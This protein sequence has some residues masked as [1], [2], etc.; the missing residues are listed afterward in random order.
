MIVRMKCFLLLSPFLNQCNFEQILPLWLSGFDS[1]EVSCLV[2]L[3]QQP[4][5]LI[6]PTFPLVQF[7]SPK[8]ASKAT[9]ELCQLLAQVTFAVSPL[10]S[11]NEPIIRIPPPWCFRYNLQHKFRLGCGLDFFLTIMA[12]DYFYTGVEKYQSFL[13]FCLELDVFSSLENE[14]NASYIC[15]S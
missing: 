14:N 7:G 8:L 9:W 3:P 4:S 10:P 1:F 11:R 15:T 5:F 2:A 12:S 13:F 6:S